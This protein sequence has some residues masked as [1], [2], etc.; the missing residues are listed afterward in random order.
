MLAATEM[1][2]GVVFG[3]GPPRGRKT[4]IVRR[5]SVC[6][7]A[8]QTLA[9]REKRCSPRKDP[10]LFCFPHSSADNTLSNR[11]PSPNLGIHRHREC[12]LRCKLL[13]RKRKETLEWMLLA[14]VLRPA[15]QISGFLSTSWRRRGYI[16]LL[17]KWFSSS[18]M[19]LQLVG[20]S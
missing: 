19:S 13:L 15:N 7:D 9:H 18:G 17:R 10:I 8:R 5:S 14:S 6:R 12:E 11:F 20:D 4:K 16:A 1:S 3:L 2:V